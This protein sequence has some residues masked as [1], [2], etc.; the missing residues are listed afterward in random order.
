MET[1]EV[2]AIQLCATEDWRRSIARATE[3]ATQAARAGAQL[4]VLPESYAGFGTA[5][6]RGRWAFDS[7]E[8]HR[9]PTLEPLLELS[10]TC[11]AWFIAGGT[12]ERA[13]RERTYNTALVLHRGRVVA[14]YRKEHLFDADLPGGVRLR[15]SH[16]TAP[17]GPAQDVVVDM[18]FA[19]VGLS[20]CFDL[21]FPD[22]YR[23][24]RERGAEVVVVPSAFTRPTGRDHWEVLLRARAIETQT[25][26]IAP[27][28]WG[29]HGSTRASWG[30]SMLVGPWG[31]V[32]AQAADSDAVVR[33]SLPAEALATAR[34]R[35]PM[36]GDS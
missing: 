4:V 25:F 31:D 2:A 14:R 3:L 12:P 6:E 24:L 16:H 34:A 36:F 15:E 32:L 9:G 19:R 13:D 22:H 30:H 18:G 5:E 20:I 33:H 27:A 10:A 7:D 28:Q 21:R 29:E 23:R 35:L 26:V 8:P 17:G 1:F 11:A